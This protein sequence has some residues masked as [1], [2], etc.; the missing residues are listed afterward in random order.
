MM[1]VSMAIQKRID[2]LKEEAN[3]TQKYVSV[4]FHNIGLV[5]AINEQC[6]SH[7]NNVSGINPVIKLN[8]SMH[9][10]D[11]ETLKT[12]SIGSLLKKRKLWL[13]FIES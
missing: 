13:Y 7:V 12:V 1:N 2:V 5:Q 8:R 11:K 4:D 6:K 3:Y 10:T 9:F